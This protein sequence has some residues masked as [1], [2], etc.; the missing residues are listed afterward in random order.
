MADAAEAN[1]I[2]D[3]EDEAYLNSDEHKKK[4]WSV[5]AFKPEVRS[6]LHAGARA[7]LRAGG[8]GKAE[9]EERAGREPEE[10]GGRRGAWA[11]TVATK[12]IL[13]RW[14]HLATDLG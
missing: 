1:V 10:W 7:T 11:Q 9:R 14:R 5:D 12:T 3:D 6:R 13:K 8:R 4:M 2:V